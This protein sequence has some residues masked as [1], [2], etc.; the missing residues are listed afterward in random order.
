[1]KKTAKLLIILLVL[2]AIATLTVVAISAADEPGMASYIADDGTE[3]Q[4]AIDVALQDAKSGTTVTLLGDCELSSTYSVT[5]DLTIDLNGKTLSSAVTMFT[6]DAKVNFTITGEGTVTTAATLFSNTVSGLNTAGED[7]KTL[8]VN[9]IG[10][11]GTDG[12]VMKSTANVN[13]FSAVS[14]TFNFKNVSITTSNKDSSVTGFLLKGDARIDMVGCYVYANS[15][16]N[17]RA[18]TF[19]LQE[20]S[21]L[22]MNYCTVKATG[23]ILGPGAHTAGVKICEISNSYLYSKSTGSG[24]AA[25]TGVIGAYC[26]IPGDMVFNNTVLSGG[27]AVF[28]TNDK[29]ATAAKV[30]LNG[31][32]IEQNGTKGNRIIR[33]ADIYVKSGSA[34]ISYHSVNVVSHDKQDDIYTYTRFYE[35][36][37]MSFNVY[38]NIFLT[39]RST[40][41]RFV[42]V[43][44]DGTETLVE[45]LLSTQ[46]TVVYDTSE[47]DYA[48]YKVVR[49]TDSTVTP[50][51]LSSVIMFENGFNNV[52]GNV[53]WSE[54]T[55]RSTYEP[56]STNFYPNQYIGWNPSGEVS[57]GSY[58]GNTCLR[59]ERTET[60]KATTLSYYPSGIVYNS[61]NVIVMDFDIASDSA[62]GWANAYLTFNVR[63]DGGSGDKKSGA[64]IYISQDG[65]KIS[66]SGITAE[67]GSTDIQN[68]FNADGW[69]HFTYVVY[70]DVT[71]TAATSSAKSG[72]AYY[73]VNG[74]FVGTAAAYASG[75]KYIYGPRFDVQSSEVGASL[76]IDNVMIRAYAEY[77]ADET[78]ASPTPK[79]YFIDSGLFNSGAVAASDDLGA[80]VVLGGIAMPEVNSAIK[81]GMELGIT[82]KLTYNV[83][84]PQTVNNPEGEKEIGTV[85]ANGYSIALTEDS[86]ASNTMNDANGDPVKYNFN[87]TYANYKIGVIWFTEF[88]AIGEDDMKFDDEGNPLNFTISEI[89][90]GEVPTPPTVADDV[91]WTNYQVVQHEG[92][93]ASYWNS[94]N[95][96]LGKD[97]PSLTLPEMIEIS[98]RGGAVMSPYASVEGK[99]MT[100][101]ILD[102]DG[103]G[104]DYSFDTQM[105]GSNALYKK[106]TTIPGATFKVLADKI[107][108]RG[109]L[110]TISEAG[111]YNIDLCG[112]LIYAN[113]KLTGG[114]KIGGKDVT[115]N[116][117]S[118]KPGG[119]I[120]SSGLEK[121]IG[122][123]VFSMH[124]GL[125]ENADLVT[126][127]STAD[128]A[129]NMHL[130]VGAYGDYPGTNLT[131]AGDN[132]FE[133]R[134]GDKTCSLT[135]DG[136]TLIHNTSDYA[137][138]IL[139]R[140]WSGDI[141]VKNSTFIGTSNSRFLETHSKGVGSKAT[142]TIDNCVIITP[143]Q[144]GTDLAWNAP[145]IQNIVD[146][147]GF[148][149]VI[150]TNTITN[151]RMTSRDENVIFYGEGCAAYD[152]DTVL[153]P[154]AGLV[155]AK[156]N[157]PMTVDMAYINALLG[158][159]TS[160]NFIKVVTPM[161]VD[162]AVSYDRYT[163]ILP[164]GTTV[165]PEGFRE[166]T[167]I[168]VVLPLLNHMAVKAEDAVKVTWA[169]LGTNK[170]IEEN[171]AKGGN[172]VGAPT[173][174]EYV[175]TAVKLV[176]TGWN[177]SFPENLTES[178]T[179]TPTYDTEA[180]IT[181]SVNLSLYSDFGINLYI[182]AE[183]EDYIVGGNYT[184]VTVGGKSYLMTTVNQS[185]DKAADNFV[186][187]VNVK[188]GDYTA[189]ATATVSIAAYANA[190][191][192]GEAFS[193]G[194][195]QL[196][197]YTVAYASEAAKYF[198]GAE[199][200]TLTALLTTYASAK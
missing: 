53:L 50:P 51:D 80:N 92:W 128:P 26:D 115:L 120:Y 16:A 62:I 98:E 5:K 189:T 131:V 173:V 103:N 70:P 102:K 172:V 197:Y 76:L 3:K 176:P 66:L 180:I 10:A 153:L 111:T 18:Y 164:Y 24:T 6:V 60:T 4:D 129:Y 157:V 28:M 146:D 14:G 61:K 127:M 27:Y 139:P 48:P 12:I 170:P 107:W 34:I 114:I 41:V 59:Y 141:T 25:E 40:G 56:A 64:Q 88:G 39:K 13:G 29:G 68:A 156:Y 145:S 23:N 72:K 112:N 100:L 119:A 43:A 188:E 44:E 7:G 95:Q 163:Y 52:A 182:P 69:N 142:A 37:R 67:E 151:G 8:T 117:Y 55:V 171:Y 161:N 113:T 110:T 116:V 186:F 124:L 168:S 160:D 155:T 177:E 179:M 167:D 150:F 82:P 57:V 147:G 104:V 47:N 165:M 159:D 181:A 108:L 137:V 33:N 148:E 9:V 21:Y 54:G 130:N 185:V 191:L 22:T 49:K 85:I 184:K 2:S 89:G 15:Q 79:A 158:N 71:D 86:F 99:K 105:W 94:E 140:Y 93:N 30:I 106:F 162:G 138:A 187:E 144:N 178:V 90:I 190:I 84:V 196:M 81:T 74:Y 126:Q 193:A 58:N 31:S 1:M 36:A 109:N 194:D 38:K 87:K 174:E 65:E 75:A 198:E 77:K 192:G 132:M 42:E 118:S 133:L 122:G 83:K 149:S 199:D 195:K 125:A 123:I 46:L 11:E 19:N 96:T 154:D 17:Q 200:T 152:F 35:G 166:G 45:P 143:Q 73:Y 175:G 91:D 183:Y 135:V 78:Y 32:V 101:A 121:S 136:A 169:A 97:V 20:S 63:G 134:Q